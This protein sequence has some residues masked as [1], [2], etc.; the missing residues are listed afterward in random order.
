MTRLFSLVVSCF[1]ILF[2]FENVHACDVCGVSSSNMG[3]GLWSGYNNNYLSVSYWNYRFKTK[4]AYGNSITDKFHQL[5]VTF[6]Y[7]FGKKIRFM[8][9]LPIKQNT[10]ILGSEQATINRRG[11]SDVKLVGFYS[12]MNKPIND[13]SAFY[14]EVGLGLSL[15]SGQFDQEI[16]EANLP[17]NFNLGNGSFSP[18]FV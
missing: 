16:H 17:L 2:S 8:A 15:P 14:S 9:S 13:D 11:I 6:R 4:P 1:L 18:I 10:R 12:W 5:D 3:I 7:A